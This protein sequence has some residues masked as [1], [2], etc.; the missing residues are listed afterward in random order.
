MNRRE[1]TMD[2]IRL[3]KS[4]GSLGV[5]TVALLLDRSPQSVRQA[6]KRYRI[7]LRKPNS[8]GGLLLG[9]PRNRSWSKQLGMDPARLEAIR[10]EA[11]SGDVDLA[12]LENRIRDL[13]SKNHRICPECVRRPI[14]RPTTGLCEPCHMSLL[15]RAHRDEADRRAARRDLDAARQEKARAK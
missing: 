1:W 4:S 11:L 7:S 3:L 10:Q 2:E 5:E 13:T 14:E 6:A 8:K 15:A 9:Q 12:E